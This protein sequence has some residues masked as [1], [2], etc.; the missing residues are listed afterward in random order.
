MVKAALTPLADNQQHATVWLGEYF[1]KYGDCAPNRDEV[2]LLIMQ[3][4]ELYD[5]YV[6]E[7]KAAKRS[8]DIIGYTRFI[9]LWNVLYPRAINRP[10]C[11]IPG[12]CNVC[13]EIDRKRREASESY[14]QEC[15]R[16]AHH[17]HRGGM[18]MLERQE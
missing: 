17:V 5:Q 9:E 12:K 4:K 7:F 1:R 13:G 15:L 8:E 18:I 11:S 16:D 3:K 2:H 14:V 10:W 6:N